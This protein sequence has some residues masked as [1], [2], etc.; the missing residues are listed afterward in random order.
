MILLEAPWPGITTVTVLPNPDLNDSE[1]K[2]FELDIGRAV[3]GT[4]YTY[5]KNKGGSKLVYSFRLSRMKALELK[6]FI[7]LFSAVKIRMTDH[8]DN[9]WEV[10]FTSNPFDFATTTRALNS[11]GGEDVE[12]TLEFEGSQL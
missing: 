6:E 8:Y 11:P 10:N 9:Q 3:D 1:N 5:V 7:R 12:I 4:V 2:K